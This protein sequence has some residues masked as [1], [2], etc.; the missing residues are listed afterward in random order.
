MAAPRRYDDEDAARATGRRPVPRMA[1][2]GAWPRDKWQRGVP[3]SEHFSMHLFLR[4]NDGVFS[5]SLSSLVQAMGKTREL[6]RQRASSK[7]AVHIGARLRNSLAPALQHHFFACYAVA[8]SPKIRIE[9]L[10]FSI[11]TLD[12]FSV[13]AQSTL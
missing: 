11:T 1:S 8:L 6:E 9:L 5:L 2:A 3:L 13:F 4:Y 12:L 10:E 7:V